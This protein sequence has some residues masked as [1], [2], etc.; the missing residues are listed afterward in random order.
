MNVNTINSAENVNL[1]KLNN[2]NK[3]KTEPVDS[4]TPVGGDIVSSNIKT[5]SDIAKKYDVKN[6]S[7]RDMA[8]MSSHLYD[9]GMIS[10]ENHALLSFQPELNQD[11]NRTIGQFTN[12]TGQPDAKRDFLGEWSDRLEQEIRDGYP[13]HMIKNTK[14]VVS[15]LE[16]M[17][18]LRSSLLA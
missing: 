10:F 3:V 12:T 13:A 14:Q 9:G 11:F 6:I 17:D 7:P 8:T 18:A 15:I 1:T 4:S 16:N 2:Y 5:V